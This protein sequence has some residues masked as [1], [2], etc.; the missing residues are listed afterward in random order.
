MPPKTLP[1]PFSMNGMPGVG[2]DIKGFSD[3]ID[4]DAAEDVKP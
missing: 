3:T 2:A 4:K 1:E